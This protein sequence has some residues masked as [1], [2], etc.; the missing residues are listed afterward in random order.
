VDL[1]SG[2]LQIEE[3]P[4]DYCKLYLGGRDFI[5]KTLLEEVP[6]GADPLGP[7]NKLIFVYGQSR[8]TNYTPSF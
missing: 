2:Q 7:K 5:I 4:E 6:K 1:T 3:L 8:S